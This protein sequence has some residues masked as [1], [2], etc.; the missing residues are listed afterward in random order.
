MISIAEVTRTEQ[1]SDGIRFFA[2][3]NSLGNEEKEIIYV[4]PFLGAGHGGFVAIPS[5]GQKI[6]VV[7]PNDDEFFYYLG[8]FLEPPKNLSSENDELKKELEDPV[9]NL[10]SQLYKARGIPQRTFWKDSKGNK[11]VLSDEYNPEYFNLKIALTSFTG[12]LLGF[13]D[14]PLIASIFMKNDHGDGITITSESNVVDAGREIKSVAHTNQEHFVRHGDYLVVVNDGREIKLCNRSSGAYKEPNSNRY[15]NI[16]LE[17]YN[18]DINL[19]ARSEQIGKIHIECTNSNADEQIV[20]IKT[21][22]NNSVVRIS[23]SG[24]IEIT[25]NGDLDINADQNINLNC[26]G[27]FSVNAGA[28]IE[29]KASS[30]VNLDGSQIHLNS[31]RA[32][33]ISPQIGTTESDYEGVYAY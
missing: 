25:T 8:S 1:I 12:K 27:S 5:P 16:N 13:I 10:D 14:S 29:L 32:S 30:N 24:K 15:G 9:E 22:S 4:S 31:N 2:H 20:Q 3:I 19:F 21:T 7:R 28:G 26:G 6:V 18:K 17:S 11:I 33:P 23:S